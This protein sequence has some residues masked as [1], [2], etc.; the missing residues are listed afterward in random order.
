MSVKQ[1]L[2]FGAGVMLGCSI[3]A[4][5]IGH[6]A[7][8]QAPR[9]VDKPEGRYQFISVGTTYI[10]TTIYVIDTQTAQCWMKQP[11]GDAPE[12]KDLG[13]PVKK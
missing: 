8:A 12:W 11:W 13:S 2:V 10:G 9:A 1:S 6:P 5:V 4:L 7:P 3:L